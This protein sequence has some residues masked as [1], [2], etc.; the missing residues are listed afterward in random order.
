[1]GGWAFWDSDTIDNAISRFSDG[2]LEEARRRVSSLFADEFDNEDAT[3]ALA[4]DEQAAALPL[5][6][7]RNLVEALAL[8]EKAE[9][10]LKTAG[11]DDREDLIDSMEAV[12][13]AMAA[14][15]DAAALPQAMAALAD[16]LYYLEN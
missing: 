14:E 6:Q 3:E 11:A 5:V 9:R 2:K 8:I 12:R 1:M 13:D 4:A 16:V 10:L 15:S 7:R